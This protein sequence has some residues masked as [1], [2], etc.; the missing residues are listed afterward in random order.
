MS[1]VGSTDLGDA[2]YQMEEFKNSFKCLKYALQE[3]FRNPKIFPTLPAVSSLTATSL[4]IDLAGVCRKEFEF[5]SALK[6]I[7]SRNSLP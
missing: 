3:Y 4:F 2:Y 6:Y 5:E 7:K 1:S